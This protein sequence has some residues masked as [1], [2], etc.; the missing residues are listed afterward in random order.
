MHGEKEAF[1]VDVEDR[2]VELFGYLAQWSILRNAGIREHDIELALLPLDLCEEA[3]K[4]AEI[5]DVSLDTGRIVSDL[6]YS[7][8]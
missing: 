5:R 7:R 8:S 1:H 6:L 4:I 3:I 2:I